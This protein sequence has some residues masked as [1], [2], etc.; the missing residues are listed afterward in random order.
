MTGFVG[1]L[2][3]L[4]SGCAAHPPVVKL[5]RAASERP[6]SADPGTL[7]P[8]S[9]DPARFTEDAV[10]RLVGPQMTCTGTLID[11]DLVLTAVHCVVK[12]GSHGEFLRELAEAKDLTI[13]LGGDFLPWGHV[14]VASIVT[15]SSPEDGKLC[16]EQGGEGDLAVLVLPRKLVGVGVM[17]PSEKPPVMMKEATLKPIGFGRCAMSGD[18]ILR[19]ERQG[20]VVS[21]M[22]SDIFEMPAAICPGDSGGPVHVAGPGPA[23]REIVGVV[24]MSAMDANDTTMK[25]SRMVRVD[26]YRPLFDRARHIADGT[27]ASELPPVACSR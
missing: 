23:S 4:L 12:R 27:P 8:S 22:T 20:G 18:G 25:L 26:A 7:P 17:T 6:T 1:V 21:W 15:L 9:V 3:G 13:E 11:E 24:S 19:T 16:G 14:G 10:V 2:A 5:V